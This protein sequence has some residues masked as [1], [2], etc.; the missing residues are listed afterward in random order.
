MYD[1]VRPVTAD[2]QFRAPCIP[3]PDVPGSLPSAR[4]IVEPSLKFMTQRLILDQHH[5]EGYQDDMQRMFAG[6]GPIAPPPVMNQGRLQDCVANQDFMG[7]LKYRHDKKWTMAS[8][9]KGDIPRN[10]VGTPMPI[11]D[12]MAQDMSDIL[13]KHLRLPLHRQNVYIMPVL[14]ERLRF[15]PHAFGDQQMLEYLKNNRVPEFQCGLLN[16]NVCIQLALTGILAKMFTLNLS[17]V[18]FTFQYDS[19]VAVVAWNYIREDRATNHCGIMHFLQMVHPDDPTNTPQPTLWFHEPHHENDG[20]RNPLPLE[21]SATAQ[22]LDIPKVFRTFAEQDNIPNCSAFAHATLRKIA[23]MGF[24][25]SFQDAYQEI[26]VRPGMPS[27]N[28]MDGHEL[29]LRVPAWMKRAYNP[30]R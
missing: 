5:F 9:R 21:V 14:I 6:F 23:L 8:F 2:E 13:E 17:T 22:A 11:P 1:C 30:F 27:F 12:L 18:P 10:L 15:D 4:N 20:A 16:Y 26:P 19:F 25:P 29:I 7:R 3:S 28:P 24:K